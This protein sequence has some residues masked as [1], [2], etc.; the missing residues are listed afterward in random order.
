MN[1][2]A[3]KNRID[4]LEIL[5]REGFQ[6]AEV[7]E[8]PDNWQTT[9]ITNIKQRR[10]KKVERETTLQLLLPLRLSWRFAAVAVIL[11]AILC[12]AYISIPETSSIETFYNL[13]EASV[14]YYDNYV[15]IAARI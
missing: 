3:D 2:N 13:N 5:A 6:A 1:I 14:D 15:E 11:A 8:L 9:V 10:R 12:L 7:P 4:K